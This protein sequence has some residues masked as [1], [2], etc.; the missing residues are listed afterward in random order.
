MIT[1]CPIIASLAAIAGKSG[2][3]ANDAQ[4]ILR[5]SKNRRCMVVVT[6]NLVE[7]TVVRFFDKIHRDRRPERLID[8]S[9]LPL[10]LEIILTK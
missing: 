6:A 1:R 8:R 7:K 3:D 9:N 5:I 10:L 2:T 4:R